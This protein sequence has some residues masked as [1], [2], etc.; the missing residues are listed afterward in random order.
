MS[1]QAKIIKSSTK[2][3]QAFTGDLVSNKFSSLLGEVLTIVDA[4]IDEEKK[5]A[6]KDLVRQAFSRKQDWFLTQSIKHIEDGE[7]L[8]YGMIA[9]TMK[10]VSGPTI[11]GNPESYQPVQE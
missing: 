3:A 1:S 7:K 2:K 5:K 11:D 8:P 4:C 9:Y 10:L 6:V